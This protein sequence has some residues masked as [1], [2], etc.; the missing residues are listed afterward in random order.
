[1]RDNNIARADIADRFHPPIAPIGMKAIRDVLTG[2]GFRGE[3]IRH[4]RHNR[5]SF[6]IDA[7]DLVSEN[8]WRILN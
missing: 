7:M 4:W 8:Q 5:K 6:N 1:L 2:H 3:R